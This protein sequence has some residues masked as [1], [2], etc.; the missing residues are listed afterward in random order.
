MF[1]AWQPEL[2]AGN[3]RALAQGWQLRQR[4]SDSTTLQHDMSVRY[5]GDGGLQRKC[6]R[7]E[8]RL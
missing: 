6:C 4:L 3:V 2:R 7:M 8:A 5:R 1:L